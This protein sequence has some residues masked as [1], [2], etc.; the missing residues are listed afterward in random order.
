MK[1]LD[2][3]KKYHN[4][5]VEVRRDFHMHPEASFE[6]HKTSERIK[7]ELENMGIQVSNVAGTGVVG[8]LKGKEDGKVVALRADID[9]LSVNEETD[10]PYSSKVPG[11]MHACGHDAHASMLLGAAKV[12]SE[13]K[14]EIKGTVKFIFQ[15]AEEIANGA[16]TMIKEGALE[17]PKVDG[18]FGMHIWSDV[19]VGQVAIDEGAVM[20]SGDV[21]ELTI[22]GK[23]CHGSSPWQG[24]D[25]ITCAAAVIQGMQTIVSRVNDARDPIVIN[26]G[27]INAGE[28]FNVVPGK[29]QI[30]GM[31]RT[32]TADT[33]KKLPGLTEKMIKSICEAYGCEYEF[34]YDFICSPTTNHEE[35]TKIAKEA[36]AKLIGEENVVS[37]GKQMGSEDFSEYVEKIPGT[38]MFLGGRNEEKGCCYSHHSNFFNID[39][40]ALPIGA[41]SYAQFAI[42]YLNK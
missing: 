11:M 34:K 39:E 16:K 27:T 22:K 24:V 37:I 6:E 20:A 25:A 4:W 18:I 36:L 19:K 32:F 31:N 23:S 8:I 9:A 2:L 21:W 17:N 26:I 13:L 10:L 1:T 5:M 12:L 35:T 28:R 29:A 33:R 15:P 7:K 14:D 40:D 38:I 41:A 42:D 30:T 3:A